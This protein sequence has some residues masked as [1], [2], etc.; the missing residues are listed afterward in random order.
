MPCSRYLRC[1]GQDL[2]EHSEQQFSLLAILLGIYDENLAIARV[3]VSSN[4]H[5]LG[6]RSYYLAPRTCGCL[7]ILISIDVDVASTHRTTAEQH[8]AVWQ[9]FNLAS[10]P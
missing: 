7:L 9:L 6:I 4:T 10:S 8:I 1:Y 2:P 3:L 5:I